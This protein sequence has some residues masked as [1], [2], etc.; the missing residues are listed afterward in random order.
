MKPLKNLLTILLI[1]LPL[2]AYAWGV[3]VSSGGVAAAGGAATCGATAAATATAHG[4]YINYPS[5][6]QGV[7]NSSSH[8]ICKVI[9]R[10]SNTT[11]SAQNFTVG[12][13]SSKGDQ[14]GTHYGSDVTVSVPNGTNDGLVTF[15]WTSDYP[16]PPGNYFIWCSAATTSGCYFSYGNSTYESTTHFLWA[17]TWGDFTGYD[18]FFEVYYME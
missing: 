18:L 7:G 16:E 14:A 1:T 8:Q 9:L 12:I 5:H 13:Y 6:C 11:G 15:E 2:S 10:C 3:V 17:E 4:S